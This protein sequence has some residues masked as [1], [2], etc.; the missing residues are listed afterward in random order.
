M[1]RGGRGRPGSL[2]APRRVIVS[3]LSQAALARNRDRTSPRS[4]ANMVRKAEKAARRAGRS[5]A[6]EGKKKNPLPFG[7]KLVRGFPH[8]GRV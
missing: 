4:D 1:A 7:G 8:A 3:R 5:E 6:C 2:L